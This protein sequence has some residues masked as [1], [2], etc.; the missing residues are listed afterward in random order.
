MKPCV[1]LGITWDEGAD[2]GGPYGPYRQTER[3]DTYSTYT[4]QL[5]ASGQ[6]ISLLLQ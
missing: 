5:L 4:Q 1:G 3:L 6:G 2:V